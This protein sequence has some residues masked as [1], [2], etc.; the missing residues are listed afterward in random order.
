VIGVWILSTFLC[1]RGVLIFDN[2]TLGGAML[3]GFILTS[4]MLGTIHLLKIVYDRTVGAF[5]EN[6]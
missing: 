3:S 1:Y 5:E 2:A 6:Y 4:S